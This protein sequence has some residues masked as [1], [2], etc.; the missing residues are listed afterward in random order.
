VLTVAVIVSVMKVFEAMNDLVAASIAVSVLMR[1]LGAVAV[2][3][4][5]ASTLY[6][7]LAFPKNIKCIWTYY[8]I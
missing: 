3:L 6:G 1:G 2:A 7:I 5:M 8:Y 4:A